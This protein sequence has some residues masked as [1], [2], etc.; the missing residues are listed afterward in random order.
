MMTKARSGLHGIS[1]HLGRIEAE[2][3]QKLRKRDDIAIEKSPD[4]IDELQRVASLDLAVQNFNR[5]SN[6]LRDVRAALQRIQEGT[7]GAC[8]QCEGAIAPRRLDALPWA[9]LCIECQEASDRI[10]RF[11][12]DPVTARRSILILSTA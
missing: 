7:F 11:S 10:D 6:L 4:E 3:I 1:E 5:E 12:D 2:L 9:S 8:I